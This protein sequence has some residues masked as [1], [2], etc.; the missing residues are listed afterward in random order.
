MAHFSRLLA[1]ATLVAG[2]RLLA[3]ETT[4]TIATVNNADMIIMQKLSREFEKTNP[5]LKL[6]WVVL[7][8][9]VLRERV[10]TDIATKGGQF[11]VLTIGT[12]E[13]PIWGQRGW[14]IPLDR[15]LSASYD[16]ADI[17]KPVR[18]GLSHE[19][20]LYALPFY[21]E[22]SFTFYRKD[23]FE[24]AG[25]KMPEQPTYDDIRKFAAATHD[26]KNGIYGIALRG[27]P[28]WGEN[29]AY[30]STLINTF[31]GRW[32]D[33]K[34]KPTIDSPEWREALGFYIDLLKKYGPPGAS[35]NGHNECRALFATGKCALWI[36]ATSAAGSIY[37]PSDSKV[38]D[39]TA[40]A[41][42]PIARVPNGASWLWS[43]ALA[44]PASSKSAPAAK[45]FVQWATS[46]EYVQLVAKTHG[47]TVAPPGTRQSTY[48]QADYVKA[49]PF[50]ETV[51][52]AILS[53]DPMHPTAKPVPYTGVQFVGIPEFQSIGTQVGQNVAAALVGKMTVDEALQASQAAA[54]RTMQRAGYYK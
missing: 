25:L 31:G 7:E 30:V 35:S 32:F 14:L 49:A 53:A 4:V 20:R 16:V 43:W 11:D 10:T 26:P 51:L 12:Y 50:A 34:W 15:D 38:A 8:E 6:H 44:V 17:L 3:A 47:W 45:K 48:A 23:L 22:S 9:N 46:K 41:K 13:A 39:K 28:G 37:N 42:A 1:L 27:K 54:E 2:Q 52:A 19:G 18:A 5:D 33:E 40:F 24:K 21:A 29:M 36:D